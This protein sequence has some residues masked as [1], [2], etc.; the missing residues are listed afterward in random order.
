MQKRWS[1]RKA[2]VTNGLF[3]TSL[4]AALLIGA[5]IMFAIYNP[6]SKTHKNP[7]MGFVRNAN[8]VLKAS[9]LRLV[10]AEFND[11]SRKKWVVA[12][13]DMIK[14]VD[15]LLGIK[16]LNGV[17]CISV[18]DFYLNVDGYRNDPNAEMFYKGVRVYDWISVP[19]H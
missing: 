11:H 1:S 9:E 17:K 10:V 7:E 4:A 2:E 15:G 13:T 14:I 3:F 5:L 6:A 12:D 16:L 18:E 8:H 19:H